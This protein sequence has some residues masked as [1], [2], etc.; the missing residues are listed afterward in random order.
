MRAAQGFMVILHFL[1]EPFYYREASEKGKKPCTQAALKSLER[2][3]RA[4]RHL[5]PC[6][7]KEQVD[8]KSTIQQTLPDLSANCYYLMLLQTFSDSHTRQIHNLFLPPNPETKRQH[9]VFMRYINLI[10][11]ISLMQHEVEL[12]ALIK[13]IKMNK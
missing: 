11:G 12:C 13:V 7:C 6:T 4:T 10:F 8:A 5:P 3:S 9:F 2:S 1:L